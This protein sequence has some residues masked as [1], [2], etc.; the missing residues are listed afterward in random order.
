MCAKIKLGGFKPPR[1]EVRPAISHPWLK[2]KKREINELSGEQE[3]QTHWRNNLR[4]RRR[5]NEVFS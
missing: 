4:C 1:I 3:K 5:N 2:H